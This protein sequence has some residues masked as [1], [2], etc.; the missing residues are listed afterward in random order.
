MKEWKWVFL[1][2]SQYITFGAQ[3]GDPKADKAVGQFITQISLLLD[4]HC[5]KVYC[6]EV[7]EIAPAIFVDGDLWYWEFEGLQRLR[8][9]K[10]HRYIEIH[11]GMPRSRWEGVNSIDI[12]KYLIDQLKDAL[13]LMLIRLNKEIYIVNDQELWTDFR[14]V[15]EEF[16]LK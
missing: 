16:L 11:I 3:L 4:K 9:S 5:N 15:E 13:D 14:K 1:M 10:K 12:K 8:L 6:T 2:K 7:D